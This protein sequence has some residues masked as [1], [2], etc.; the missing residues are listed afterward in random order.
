MM[1]LLYIFFL[2][3]FLSCTSSST[4]EQDGII[5]VNDS[6]MIVGGWRDQPLD[7]Q[8][9]KDDYEILRQKLRLENPQVKLLEIIRVE[10]QV[11]AGYNVRLT[12]RFR[13]A[14]ESG[15]IVAVF[16]HDLRQTVSLTEI[17]M[18]RDQR[19]E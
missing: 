13:N 18:I 15:Q 7:W 9:A 5:G 3:I 4:A 14:E 11:V 19:S 10:T 8:T 2:V 6:D 16:Y 1:R 12:V 17:E